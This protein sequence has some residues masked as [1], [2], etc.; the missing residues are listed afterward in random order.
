MGWKIYEK[1]TEIF[2]K[3]HSGGGD[4]SWENEVTTHYV[5]EVK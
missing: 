5:I 1:V 2:R 4:C 3:T